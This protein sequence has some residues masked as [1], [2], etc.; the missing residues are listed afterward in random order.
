MKGN[1]DISKVLSSAEKELEKI[2]RKKLQGDMEGVKREI[3][4]Y[5]SKISTVSYRDLLEGRYDDI[6][7]VTYLPEYIRF[8]DLKVEKNNSTIPLLLN[9]SKTDGILTLSDNEKNNAGEHLQLITLRL[10]LSINPNLFKILC[11]DFDDFGRKTKILTSLKEIDFD[12]FTENDEFKK[13]ITDIRNKVKEF[14]SGKFGIHDW[15]CDYNKANPKT[16]IPYWIVFISSVGSLVKSDDY[17]SLISE[18]N[19]LFHNN[20]ASRAGCYFIIS[21]KSLA[22]R[23]N[24]AAFIKIHYNKTVTEVVS[25]VQDIDTTKSGKLSDLEI[26]L[27]ELDVEK[28]AELQNI[29]KQQEILHKKS[30]IHEIKGVNIDWSLDTSASIKAEI[31][32]SKDGSQQV[33]S[34]GNDSNCHHCLIG[35]GTGSG[36]SILLHAL[37]YGLTKNYSPKDLNLCLLDYKEGTEFIVYEKLPHTKILSA[38]SSTKY[39]VKVLKWLGE[40]LT[41]RGNL[42]KEAGV[43]NIVSYNSKVNQDDKLPRL[44]IIIDEFQVLLTYNNISD[45]CSDL[46]EDISKRGRSF[47]VNLILASQSLLGVDLSQSTQNQVSLRIC[48]KISESDC[49]KLLGIDNNLPVTFKGPGEGLYNSDSGEVSANELFQASFISTE[50]I[51]ENVNEQNRKAVKSNYEIEKDIYKADVRASHSISDIETSILNNIPVIVA[52][53]NNL[54]AKNKYFCLKNK[55]ILFGSEN[56]DLENII[57]SNMVLILSKTSVQITIIADNELNLESCN[58]LNYESFLESDALPSDICII[59]DPEKSNYLSGFDENGLD[60]FDMLFNKIN[61]FQA[62]GPTGIHIITSSISDLNN[63]GINSINQWVN[64][65]TEVLFWES[66][67]NNLITEYGEVDDGQEFDIIYKNTKTNELKLYESVEMKENL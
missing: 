30:K 54:F 23:F 59:I 49:D 21:D 28:I 9:I 15:L 37:I 55:N 33:F 20:S 64:I 11:F 43:Q 13:C 52:K 3:D 27:P 18:L 6:E 58:K 24:D 62:V 38:G 25:G 63:K 4:S 50:T 2:E 7:H 31:G 32:V 29:L 44:L 42:F 65:F 66:D 19:K 36:K 53:D 16:A 35:G 5:C 12:L 26:V 46:I 61:E 67:K 41:R 39:G 40:E 45:N 1:L 34:L 60:R 22:E 47:G 14:N 8:G 17:E 57:L 10:V 48:L 56:K 51:I